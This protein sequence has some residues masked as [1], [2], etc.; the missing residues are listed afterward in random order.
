[1]AEH[2]GV[3]WAWY[4]YLGM[5]WRVTE[6]TVL[7]SVTAFTGFYIACSIGVSAGIEAWR[8]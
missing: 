8:L 1:M 5:V 6:V 3:L 7:V 4:R 2:A